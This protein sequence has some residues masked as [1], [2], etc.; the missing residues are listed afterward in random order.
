MKTAHFI[1]KVQ[2]F[3]AKMFRL[4]RRILVSEDAAKDAVQE[5]L[6][7]LWEKVN[8]NSNFNSIEAYAMQMTKNHCL[9]QL[10]LKANQNLH[11]VHDNFE[12]EEDESDENASHNETR[13]QLI[14]NVM[15]KLPEQQKM[16]MQLR[17][18]ENYSFTEI[19]EILNIS[20][21]AARVNLS[22]ARKSVIQ[23]IKKNKAYETQTK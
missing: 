9:D 7:K 17:D 20:E 19:A 18:I 2:M 1:E 3:E 22:R 10:K 15:D 6:L 12:A 23:K 11:L 5:V 21:V 4:A 16:V 13:M 14:K 8:Q